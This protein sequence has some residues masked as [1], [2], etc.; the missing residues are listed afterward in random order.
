[1]K[2]RMHLRNTVLG[3]ALALPVLLAGCATTRLGGA[4]DLEVISASE[5]PRS[6]LYTVGDAARPYILGPMDRLTIEVIAGDEAIT[7]Q[8]EVDANGNVIFPFAGPVHVEGT[9]VAQANAALTN[10]LAQSYFQDPQVSISLLEARSK[11]VTV[12]GEV[13]KPGVYPVLGPTSLLQVMAI[14]G[15]TEDTAALDAVVVFRIVEGKRY[16]ALYSLRAIRRGAYADPELFAG[17]IVAV[18]DSRTRRFFRD[19][20]TLAPLLT[21]PI[22]LID[23][24]TH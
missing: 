14:A 15:G 18:N 23:R 6:A 20:A 2:M 3:G 5:L 19:A 10:R 1:M 7:R 4:P 9:T 21:A 8:V 13:K 24:L 17:D 22:I 16:A 12:E 11:T